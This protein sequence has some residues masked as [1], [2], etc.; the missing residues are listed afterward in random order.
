[1][2]SSETAQRLQTGIVTAMKAK[3]K[4]RLGVLRQV[5]AAIKQVEVDERRD[6][7]ETDVLKVLAAYAKK[8]KDQIKAFGD[9]GRDDLL[10]AAEAE[11][12]IVAEYLPAELSDEKLEAIVAEVVAET[13]ATSMKDMGR[14]IKEVM[15]RTTGRADGARVSAVVKKALAG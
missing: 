2:A 7:Q 4:G 11:L 5:Q 6:L 3:D 15:A 1:M 12:A 13:G 10:Q 8:V 14:V 9:G